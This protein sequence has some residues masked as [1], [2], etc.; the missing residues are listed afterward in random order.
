MTVLDSLR[1]PFLPHDLPGKQDMD[2]IIRAHI[3]PY[4]IQ[5]ELL[6]AGP[7]K[8][9]AARSSA[10]CWHASCSSLSL[11]YWMSPLLCWM[12]VQA[13]IMDLLPGSARTEYRIFSSHDLDLLRREQPDWHHAGES[14]WNKGRQRPY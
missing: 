3:E 12:S 4:G 10:L 14:C 9:A 6:S 7:P 11:L 2:E 1:E 5:P 13:Q 8:S